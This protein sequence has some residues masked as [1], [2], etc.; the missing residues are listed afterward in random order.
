MKDRIFAPDPAYNVSAGPFW[1]RFLISLIFILASIGKMA[2]FD[3]NVA[4]LHEASVDVVPFF[5]VLGLIL[6]FIGG[7]LLLFG[8][9]TR[10]AVYILMIYQFPVLFIFH[11][12]WHYEGMEMFRQLG[13]FMRMLVIYGGLLLLWSY[14][15]GTWSLDYLLYKKKRHEPSSQV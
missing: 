14:G 13:N 5:I 2:A 3:L 8:L 6:Q 4:F 11:S 9:C 7:V 15:P 1:G 12:F 10:I